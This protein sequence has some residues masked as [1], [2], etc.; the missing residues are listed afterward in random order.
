MR[1]LA[2]L[3]LG[4]CLLAVPAASAPRKGTIRAVEVTS[5]TRQKAFLF[6][7]TSL[8]GAVRG[9]RQKF[10]GEA[11]AWGVAVPIELPVDVA[12]QASG[13]G[14]DA[15]F[16]VNLSLAALPKALLDVGSPTAVCRAREGPP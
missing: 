14:W 15:V 10:R 13:Q 16:L 2:A 6:V 1:R 4:S 7:R 12:V 5:L 11:T 3:A 9:A 8:S